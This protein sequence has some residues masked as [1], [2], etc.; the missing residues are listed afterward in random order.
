[1]VLKPSP[2]PRTPR[3]TSRSR[4]S[5]RCAAIPSTRNL[6]ETPS[7]AQSLDG[8]LRLKGSLRFPAAKFRPPMRSRASR[9]R[10]PLPACGE[11]VGVRGP[12]RWAQNRGAQ[13]RGDAPS[14]SL[15]ATSPRTRG[16]INQSEVADSVLQPETWPPLKPLENQRLRCSDVPWV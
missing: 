8:Y 4:I 10:L 1:M 5:K 9:S 14:P 15:R 12:V 2:K 6:L 7:V 11:R 3:A 13:N 16:E